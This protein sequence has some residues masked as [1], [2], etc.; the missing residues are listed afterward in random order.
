M[1]GLIHSIQTLGAVDGPG[2]R[3]VA[4][5]QGCPLRCGYCHNPDAQPLTGG[6]AYTPQALFALA[7]R[8]RSYFG[9]E[10]GVTLSGGEPLLQAPFAQAFF[11]LC[12][13]GGIHTA[14]D[15][16]GCRLDEPV[17]GLLD[18]TDL[19]LL[20]IKFTIEADYQRYAGCSLAAPLR[21]LDELTARNIP[22]WIRQ[23]IVPTLNDDEGN[24][25]RLNALL[26]G[27]PNV[28]KVELLPFRKLCQTKYDALGLPFPFGHLPEAVPDKVA[29]LQ[30]KVL[31]PHK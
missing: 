20:D 17:R 22:C 16:S 12:R 29:K 3:F 21:F 10:G 15:T 5:V 31:L 25:A 6:Q 24:I 28:R 19:V 26:A 14:L 9:R 27:H 23:V 18:E 13:E 2:V 7:S 30:E 1:E 11:A 8:Y 4:F